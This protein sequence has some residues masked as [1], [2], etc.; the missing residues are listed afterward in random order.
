MNGTVEFNRRIEQYRNYWALSHVREHNGLNCVILYI[1]TPN[2]VRIISTSISSHQFHTHTYIY[3]SF[4]IIH[5]RACDTNRNYSGD[6]TGLKETCGIGSRTEPVKAFSL[7]HCN[8][9]R[10]S[11][12]GIIILLAREM[13][14]IL[15]QTKTHFLR[16]G[17]EN[18]YVESRLVFTAMLKPRVLYFFFFNKNA[19]L[20]RLFPCR[21]TRV[22]APKKRDKVRQFFSLL[23]RCPA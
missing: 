18:P 7:F 17:F 1:H 13:P 20:S 19:Q 15:F 11:F 6:R 22:R 23:I 21:I 16:K 8:R 10:Q 4:L 2:D 14:R 12:L 5:A 3:I 9:I